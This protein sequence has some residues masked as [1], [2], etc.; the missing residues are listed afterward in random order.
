[1]IAKLCTHAP[2]RER[3]IAHMSDALDG[4]HI[5]GIQHNIPF[6]AA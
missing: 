1:M 6:L 4:F 2:D 5:D 3:A